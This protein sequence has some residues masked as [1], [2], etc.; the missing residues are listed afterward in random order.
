MPALAALATAGLLVASVPPLDVGLA[1]WVAFW[2]LLAACRDRGAGARLALGSVAGIAFGAGTVGLWLLPAA[3]AHLA[4]GAPSAAALT[5]AAAWLYGGLYIALLALIH[6]FLPRPRW[7][8]TAAVWVLLEWLRG[9]VAGGAPW[10]L[11]GHSQH[12][13]LV[14]QIAELGGVPAVSFLLMLVSAALAERGRERRTGLAVALLAVAMACAFG[15]ERLLALPPSRGDAS[16]V[17]VA[18]VSGHHLAADPLRAYAEATSR[19]PADVVVWPE[20]STP[21]YLQEEDEAL[22]LLAALA[23]GHAGL[24]VGGRRYDGP[25]SARRYFNSVFFFDGRGGIAGVADKQRLVPLAE[26]SALPWLHDLPRPFAPAPAP[27]A[28]VEVAGIRI[29]VL[30][31]WEVL[32]DDLARDLVRRGADL[33]VNLSSD[34]DLGDG[35]G[36]LVAFAR[37]RAIETR[38]WLARASGTGASV[39]IDPAGRVHERG[40]LRIA[41]DVARPLTLYTRYGGAVPPIAALLVALAAA[42]EALV[43]LRATR[44]DCRSSVCPDHR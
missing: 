2:P 12:G 36:Q 15:V 22:G 43:R 8:T 35:A 7:L 5:L 21:G 40:R 6:P 19:T 16:G 30:V 44:R 13:A 20:G 32:F 4:T 39:L 11:L 25:P 17:E 1:A 3:R 10:A 28:P 33:L 24:V 9:F 41:R 34:R 29:G 31:C 37:F 27:P 14:A 38:R 42:R 18:L 26:S 23:P